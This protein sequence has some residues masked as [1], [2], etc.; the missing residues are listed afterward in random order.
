MNNTLTFLTNLRSRSSHYEWLTC[1]GVQLS[2]VSLVI[3]AEPCWLVHWLPFSPSHLLV[4][5]GDTWVSLSWSQ[6]FCILV[7]NVL[8]LFVYSWFNLE[9]MAHSLLLWELA[10]DS[11]GSCCVLKSQNDPSYYNTFFQWEI[12][13]KSKISWWEFS[14][15]LTQHTFILFVCIINAPVHATVVGN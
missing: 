12:L 6:N 5:I 7:W 8:K 15:T 2:S 1:E 3:S 11:H 13:L 9:I 14:L 10:T 4:A